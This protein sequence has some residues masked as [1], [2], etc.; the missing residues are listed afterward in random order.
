MRVDIIHL[1]WSD[2]FGAKVLTINLYPNSVACIGQFAVNSR[3]R[4]RWLSLIGVPRQGPT[5]SF[6]SLQACGLQL[7]LSKDMALT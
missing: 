6:Y 1:G 4:S 5:R 7:G 3:Y 2:H